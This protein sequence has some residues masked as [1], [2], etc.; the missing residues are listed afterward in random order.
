MKIVNNSKVGYDIKMP[1]SG[2]KRWVVKYIYSRFHCKECNKAFVPTMY[3]TFT[4]SK[5][6]QNLMAWVIYRHIGRLKSQQS[7]V[8]DLEEIFKY[9][10]PI[11]IIGD[12]KTR[13]AN[14]YKSAY[15]E[16]W[17]NLL[18]GTLLHVDETK[19]SVRGVTNYVWAFANINTVFYI[20]TKTREGDFLKEKLSGFNGVLV[21]DFYTAYDSISCVQQK[22]LIHLIRDINDDILKNPF[23]YEMKELGKDFTALLT[24]I[25]GTIDKYGLKKRHLHKHRKEVQGFFKKLEIRG[26]DSELARNFQRRF[27]KYKE[28]LFLFL[29]YDGI[30]WNNNN[31]EHA[32]KRFVFLRNIINGLS[33][34][35][36]IKEYLVLLSIC[37]TLRL[38]NKSFLKFLVA[39]SA[40]MNYSKKRLT[41]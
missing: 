16:L 15:N 12:F 32:I 1:E 9:H 28:K 3:K 41:T 30:P 22:C 7:I 38:N 34:E 33:T 19:V 40:D 36:S 5:Y 18:S 37:E 2:I 13:A 29:N 24:P 14:C 20:H 17:S 31:A 4:A 6:G 25:I 39:K 23:D 21:S 27:V 35:E 8:E 26:Y 10:F 11:S